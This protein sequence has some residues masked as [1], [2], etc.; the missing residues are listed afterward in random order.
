MVGRPTILMLSD[1][2]FL[3]DESSKEKIIPDFSLEG[4]IIL[5]RPGMTGNF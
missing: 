3:S 1:K 2:L 4:Q 5:I